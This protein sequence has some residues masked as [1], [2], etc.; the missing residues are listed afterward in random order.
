MS[1]TY[2][3]LRIESIANAMYNNVK[4]GFRSKE[5]LIRMMPDIL[6]DLRG[7][8]RFVKREVYCPKHDYR[9]AA[10]IKEGTRGN[11]GFIRCTNFAT[12]L[13]PGSGYVSFC[14]KHIRCNP[15]GK[16]NELSQEAIRILQY[17][18]QCLE[19][20]A[21]EAR[22][23]RCNAY[24]SKLTDDMTTLCQCK[25]VTTNV[26][27]LC[28]SHTNATLGT[29]TKGLTTAGQ[30]KLRRLVAKASQSTAIPTLC[31]LP[32]GTIL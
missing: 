27:G 22:R 4:N 28:G 14:D 32:K 9:C 2:S 7:V 24:T 20:D 26:T 8:A 17:K 3:E 23:Q 5:E 12:Y 10:A 6:E 18:Q 25:S 1:K 30:S 21:R 11:I 31:T 29:I 15:Y 19:R 13:P 16:F